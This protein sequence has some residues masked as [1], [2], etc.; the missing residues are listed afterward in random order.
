M[1]V[2]L[3]EYL[4]SPHCPHHH[5]PCYAFH[6]HSSY[7]R[8]QFHPSGSGAT[9][10]SGSTDRT[11]KIW[12]IE[13]GKC[14]YTLRGHTGEVLDLAFSPNGAKIVTASA[15]QTAR[16][17]NTST[18][19]CLNILTGHAGEVSK[20]AIDPQGNKIATA[21]SDKTCCVWDLETGERLQVCTFSERAYG[22][23]IDALLPSSMPLCFA[24][25]A[26]TFAF[27][28]SMTSSHLLGMVAA[29]TIQSKIQKHPLQQPDIS[30][31]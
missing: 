27:R 8:K 10:A 9:C 3:E 15:D 16:V 29:A 21:S 20:V 7:P 6:H 11:C 12:D 31:A 13:T 19:L 28:S 23:G 1:Q 30:G 14:I 18:G 22:C 5:C 25:C 17:Y 26:C 24:L 2:L 4:Y